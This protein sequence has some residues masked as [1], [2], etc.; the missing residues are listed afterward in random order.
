VGGL[1]TE[2]K[3]TTDFYV[4]VYIDPRNF[5]E[6]YYGKGRGSRK[7]AHLDDA[8]DTEK[9]R[10]IAAIKKEGLEPI[11]RVVARNMSEKDALLVEKTLL[12]RLGRTLTN[13]ATGHF[14]DN[15][16]PQD[17]MHLRMPGF[18][19]RNGIYYYN[20][21]DGLHRCWEDYRE[22]SFISAGQ[23]PQ[24]RD[25]I[26]AFS[27]GDII[28]AYLKGR[29]FVGIGRIA[30]EAVPIR[31]AVVA[32]RPL[33]GSDLQCRQM[34]DNCED[35]EMCEYVALVTWLKSVPRADAKWNKSSGLYTTTHIR[36]S[37]ERQPQ[38]IEFLEEQF[39]VDLGALAE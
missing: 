37:L 11:I 12:W 35:D 10:R 38:T 8:T 31:Q 26:K 6:F 7:H 14:G 16:R 28:A 9:T 27:P 39:D 29:G 1:V 34:D 3:M 30:A 32:G 25:Q 15:F 22:H 24:W 20:V 13:V 5:E 18:D 36:A 4:Y 2:K 17:T 33:L 21:G 23:G 19:F